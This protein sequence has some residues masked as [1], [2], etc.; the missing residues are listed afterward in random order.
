MIKTFRRIASLATLLLTAVWPAAAESEGVHIS[1]TG[2]QDGDEV[3]LME[4][5]WISMHLLPRMQ[6]IINR[7][8][9][10][11]TGNDIVAPLQ[12]KIRRL[13]GGILMD[14]L[15]EQDWRFQELKEKPYEF[16][17]TKTGPDEAQVV[18]ET[19]IEGWVGSDNSGV[20]SKLLSNLTL[21]RTVTLK[22]GQPFVR[23]DFEFINNDKYAKRPTFWAHNSSVVAPL[24]LETVARPSARGISE[25]TARFREIKEGR[26]DFL[27]DFNHGWSARLSKDRKEGIVYLM[28]YDY[29]NFLYDCGNTT[30]EWTYDSILSFKDQPWKGRVY[31][32][33]MIGM[34]EVDYANEYFI[35]DLN[36]RRGDGKLAVDYY[37][38]SSY[39]KAARVTFNTEVE[40]ELLA[41]KSAA[42]KFKPVTVDGIGIQP[43]K[44]HTEI[45]FTATDPLLFNITAYV[46]LPDG[47]TKKFE[48]QNFHV[49]EYGMGKNERRDGKPVKLL[50]RPVAKPKI[51]AMPSGLTINREAFN[52]FGV[53]GLGSER[54]GLRQAVLA[55]PDARL[56]IG[57]CTGRDVY[58]YG[59]GDF[60]YD[61][62][63]L[64][65]NRVMILSNIQDKEIRRIGASILLPWLKAGGGLVIAGGEN[66]FTFELREHEVNDYY[67]LAVKGHSLR[68]G[69]ARLQAPL[70][71]DHPIFTGI[72][73]ED[74]PYLFYYH[75]LALKTKGNANVLMTAGSAPF[76]V[77]H[78]KDNQITMVVTANIFGHPDE[79]GGK[80]HLRNWPEWPRLFAN[81]VRYAGGRL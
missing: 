9:F 21:R 54:M 66:A 62:D 1:V 15:W 53:F 31:I 48:F 23:F 37:L 4:S 18:F 70:V 7:F 65:N 52:V 6:A 63:R 67:P 43:E 77:E 74:P 26:E 79:F 35:C 64:F 51:P 27:Y 50:Y 80:T 58:G 40:Y 71:P 5:E 59:L 19:D 3:I 78:R 29:I 68:K 11:P 39:E 12:P 55:I 46:E 41:E 69:P 17:I 61:F 44:G 33:P 30:C 28:D 56:E 20:I 45:D 8:V 76:I 60:P 42:K 49:G 32:L 34:S 57:Y 10:R 72:S 16:K 47:T 2:D 73:L 75:D 13:G 22:S 24:G 25:Y 36:V 14:C 38:T 81:I